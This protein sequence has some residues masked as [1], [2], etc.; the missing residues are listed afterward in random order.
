MKVM[1]SD[2]V[3]KLHNL[4]GKFLKKIQQKMSLKTST[5]LD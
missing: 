4:T 3:D 5:K 2:C 1:S